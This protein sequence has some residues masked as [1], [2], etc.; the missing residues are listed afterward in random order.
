MALSFQAVVCSGFVDNLWVEMTRI[1][2]A[3]LNSTSSAP[4]WLNF[5]TYRVEKAVDILC[6][7]I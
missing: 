1:H 4:L 3:A 7:V 6:G 5:H 2:I